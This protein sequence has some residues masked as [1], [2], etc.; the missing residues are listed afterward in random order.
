MSPHAVTTSIAIVA[1]KTLTL[2]LGA[3]ITYL[4]YRAYRRTRA[5]PLRYL[6]LGFGTITFGTLLAGLVDQV[7]NASIQI[8]LLVETALIAVGFGIIVYSLYVS[9]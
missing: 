5:Q 4:S 1:L 9:E 2:V 6:S 8:G 3:V 7:L